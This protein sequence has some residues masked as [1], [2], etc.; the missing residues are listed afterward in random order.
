MGMTYD[1]RLVPC[2]ICGKK[3]SVSHYIIDGF[4]WGWDAGCAAFCLFDGVHGITKDVPFDLWPTVR[5]C[6]TKEEA[7][8]KYNEKAKC[9][10]VEK[11]AKARLRLGQ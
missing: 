8:N 5:G 7:I 3:A 11:I 6:N 2:P 1:K 4:D 10:T 9:I